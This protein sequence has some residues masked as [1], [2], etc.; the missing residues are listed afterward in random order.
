MA[1]IDET[2]ASLEREGIDSDKINQWIS[3]IDTAMRDAEGNLKPGGVIGNMIPI[4]LDPEGRKEL[5][6]ILKITFDL[7][8]KI[9]L[10]LLIDPIEPYLISKLPEE[11]RGEYEEEYKD[12]EYV[13]PKRTLAE[14][15]DTPKREIKR[16][17]KALRKDGWGQGQIAEK[18]NIHEKSLSSLI[19]EIKEEEKQIQERSIIRLLWNRINQKIRSVIG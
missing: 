17:I 14:I 8:H 2:V 7:R 3:H 1:I 10:D 6:R 15:T 12:R 13:P 5:E 16:E 4:L 9:H 18:M 11:I 19:G